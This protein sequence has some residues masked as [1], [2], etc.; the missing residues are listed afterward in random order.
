MTHGRRNRTW[1]IIAVL[2]VGLS[3]IGL[4]AEQQVTAADKNGSEEVL[5]LWSLVRETGQRLSRH[6]RDEDDINLVMQRLNTDCGA[7]PTEHLQAR[8]LQAEAQQMDA[9]NGLEFRGGFTSQDIDDDEDYPR[10]YVEL[11]W[12]LLRNGLRQNNKRAQALYSESEIAKLHYQQKRQLV[13][14][15]CRRYALGALFAALRGQLLT[16]K[17]ELLEPVYRIE[18]RAYFKGW[19]FLDDLLVSDEDLR[20]TRR[21]LERLVDNWMGDANL[22]GELI[23]PPVIDVRLDLVI[24]AI[25]N[26]DRDDRL[27]SLRQKALRYRRESK[28][29]NRLRLFLRQELDISGK[30]DDGDDL[31]A[32]LRFQVPLEWGT[33]SK[34]SLP[35]RLREVEG[36]VKLSKWERVARARSA[37]VEVREQHRR[38]I[39]LQYRVLR[40]RERV[41]RVIAEKNLGDEVEVALA[42]A[43]MRTLLDSGIELIGAKEELYRRVY[44]LFLAA[45]VAYRPEM[46]KVGSG[47]SRDYRARVGSRGIYLWSDAFNRI[48]DAQLLDF[49]QAK[50]IDRVLLS[51]GRRVDHRKLKEFIGRATDL[52]IGIEIIVGDNNWIFPDNQKRAATAAA[53]AAEM[54]GALHLDIE[55]HTLPGYKEHRDRYLK[56]YLGLMRRVR[57]L[58]GDQRLGLALPLHWPPHYYR[59]LAGIADSLYLMAYEIPDVDK[60][61]KRISKVLVLLPPGKAVIVLRMEDFKDQWALEQAFEQIAAETGVRR[62]GIHK[63]GSFF[64]ETAKSR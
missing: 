56:N 30:N 55:P 15:R 9:R 24:D 5:R 36:D 45:R 63:L 60:L 42:V 59:E 18:R 34:D 47:M 19:S 12:D 61:I 21:E 1:L 33:D 46:L 2:S 4:A 7:M 27:I 37:Y 23:N 31:V 58:M 32:G 39:R 25:R 64:T 54:T 22:S 20:D 10:S 52:N 35:Y 26:D 62:F 17:L 13:D 57:A 51:A 38:L 43:R 50:G 53:A 40:A 8:A 28:D 16:L 41:R 29:R 3:G 6:L 14:H 48:P 11:S 49:L 44:G